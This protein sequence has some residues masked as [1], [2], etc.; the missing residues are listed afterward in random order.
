[1]HRKPEL[2]QRGST[3]RLGVGKTMPGEVLWRAEWA[4]PVGTDMTIQNLTPKQG[5]SFR[6]VLV[7]S[8]APHNT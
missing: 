3:E 8:C 2:A 6:W 1:M 7:S 5:R 4:S